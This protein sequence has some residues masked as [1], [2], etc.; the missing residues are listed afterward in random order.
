MRQVHVNVYINAPIERVFD[1]VTDHEGFLR[2]E[3]GTHATITRPGS[4][5]RNGLGCLR[6]VR[7]PNGVRFVEEVTS[8]SPPT[9]YEY[10]IQKTSLPLRHHGGQV[11]LTARGD[12]TEIN[13]TS[14]FDLT[15]PL[16]GGALEPIAASILTTK[17][18]EMLLA[19]KAR[20][21]GR[22]RQ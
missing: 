6:E 13:W 2:G 14:R 11:R 9:S 22:P 20:L 15:V 8:F 16:V 3:D 17:F 12:G 4:P 5:D 21:E 18:T 10:Q 1:A 19:A 7:A